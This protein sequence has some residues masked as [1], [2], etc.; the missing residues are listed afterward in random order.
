MKKL[1]EE[2]NRQVL[3]MDHLGVAFIV[4]LVPLGLAFVVFF[5]EVVASATK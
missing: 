1:N 3:T 4:C 5:I 2:L